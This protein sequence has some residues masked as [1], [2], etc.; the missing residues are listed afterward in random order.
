MFASL[1]RKFGQL[2]SD[3]VLR[4]WLIGRLFGQWPGEPDYVAHKPP[5]LTLDLTGMR[6]VAHC[7]FKQRQPDAPKAPLTMT[8]AG[9]DINLQIN[10]VARLFS[11]SFE[12]VETLLSLHRFAWMPALDQEIDA[13]WVDV[14]WAQWAKLYGRPDDSWVWH[15][16][17]ASERAINI[18]R[19]ALAYG[20]A[21]DRDEVYKILVDHAEDIYEKLEY[22]GDHHTSN[23]LANNGRGLYLLG[24]W[25]GMEHTRAI[26]LKILLQEAKRIFTPSGLLREGSSHYHLLLAQNYQDVYEAAKHAG[27]PEQVDLGAIA[28]RAMSH[29]NLLIMPGGLALIGDISPDASPEQVVSKLPRLTDQTEPCVSIDGW[30]RFKQ[31]PWTGLWHVAPG[32]WSHMPGHGHQDLGS[33]EVHYK[34]EPLFID[35]GRGTYGEQG[36]AALYRSALMHNGVTVDDQDPYPP[37]RPYYHQKF[38]D[39]IGGASPLISQTNSEIAL[40]FTS[41]GTRNHRRTWQFLDDRFTLEDVITGSGSH[42]ITR[43]LHTTLVPELITG[44]VRLTG[45]S[46]FDL[47]CPEARIEINPATRWVAYGRGEPAYQIKISQMASLPYRGDLQVEVVSHAP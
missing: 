36:D 39:F 4:R 6:D 35:L 19:F 40:D 27:R 14:I 9:L 46:K 34:D 2:A 25:L 31:G 41:T 43:R 15:P 11:R 37:N 47:I 5:Y 33:F 7:Q 23:H 1:T 29:A 21:G 8:L 12:D 17:T 18:L 30:T 22:F 13:N 28:S 26:G 45:R 32:G 42:Q 38:R 16:Y 24:L 20:W 44:G 3:P 10:D